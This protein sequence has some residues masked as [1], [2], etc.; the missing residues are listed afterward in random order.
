[1]LVMHPTSY[2]NPTIAGNLNEIRVGKYCSIADSATFDGGMQHNTRFVTTYP[3]WRM[4][5]AENRNGMC[6]GDIEIGNDVWIGDGAL[7]ISGVKIGDGAVVGARAIV[8]HDVL[9]YHIVGGIPAKTIRPRFALEQ[10][11]RLLEIRW[12]D[13]PAE[14]ILE[15]Q[16]LLLSENINTFIETHRTEG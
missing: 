13:W 5:A 7:I 16:H 1:M 9:P 2:G 14:K 12:W 10:I 4:G 6:L 8:T 11:E 3:L 15:N